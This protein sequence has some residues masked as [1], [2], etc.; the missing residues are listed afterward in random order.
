MSDDDND[1]SRDNTSPEPKPENTAKNNTA[2]AGHLGIQ[3]VTT[4][5]TPNGTAKIL[6]FQVQ[7]AIEADEQTPV[8][9]EDNRPIALE[10]G[11]EAVDQQSEE[12]GYQLKPMDEISAAAAD[13]DAEAVNVSSDELFID[14]GTTP[15]PATNDPEV[16]AFY[17]DQGYNMSESDELSQA[18]GDYDRPQGTDEDLKETFNRVQSQSI[19]LDQSKDKGLE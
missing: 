6:N 3:S 9:P 7:V 8:E 10:T 1:G 17:T 5:L 11:D 19:V 2:P 18:E 15:T 14:D 4:A 12:D 13:Q 16:N